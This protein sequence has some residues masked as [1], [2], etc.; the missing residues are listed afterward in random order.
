MKQL[1]S[2]IKIHNE[3]LTFGN[4]E[5]GKNKFYSHKTPIFLGDVD[6]E[7]ILVF[8][9]VKKSISTLYVTFIMVKE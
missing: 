5:I 8:L 1:S 7:N 9:L 3:I 2:Y 4:T 6:I